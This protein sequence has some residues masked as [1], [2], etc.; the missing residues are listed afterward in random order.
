MMGLVEKFLAD[1]AS[2]LWGPPLIILLIGVGLY[3]TVLL[4]GVQ[5]RAFFHAFALIFKK[6]KEF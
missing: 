5:F 6:E 1:L 4:K 3:L 2:F